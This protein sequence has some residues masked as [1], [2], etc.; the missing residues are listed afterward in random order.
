MGRSAYALCR[1]CA[2]SEVHLLPPPASL[3]HPA[4]SDL[5]GPTKWCEA[6]F[7]SCVRGWLSAT[8]QDNVGQKE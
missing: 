8:A 5:N 1:S 3:P 6:G 2:Y 4:S 7:P